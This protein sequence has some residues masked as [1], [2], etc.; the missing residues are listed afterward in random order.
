[1]S[2]QMSASASQSV[3]HVVQNGFCHGSM[4]A[5]K[6]LASVCCPQDVDAL[7]QVL[8]SKLGF[9]SVRALKD[10]TKDQVEEAMSQMC[11]ALKSGARDDVVLF[12][13]SGHVSVGP[14]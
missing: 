6:R 12:F 5:I 2:L 1:M 9:T 3:V 13:F 8:T 11:T 7:Q 14:W 4:H 10:V